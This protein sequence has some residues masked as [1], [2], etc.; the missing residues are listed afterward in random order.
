MATVEGM[1]AA[2]AALRRAEQV[3]AAGGPLEKALSY[4]A[5]RLERYAISITHV[6]KGDLK[7]AHRIRVSSNRAEIYLDP[8]AVN[9]KG[10]RPAE[11]GVYEHARGG[12]HAFYQR[13]IDEASD[14]VLREAGDMLRAYL[15]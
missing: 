4:A 14:A 1:A 13:T 10:R 5:T 9:A 7:G 11:Y 2:Q 8:S 12:S 15:R 3:A 6:D